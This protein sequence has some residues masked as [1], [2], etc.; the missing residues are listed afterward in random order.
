MLTGKF[1]PLMKII[2]VIAALCLVA[3]AADA[4]TGLA[5]L[6]IPVGARESALGGA[7]A[8]L[9][10]GPT[11]AVYNPALAAFIPRSAALMHNRHFGDS[12][13]E[14]VGFTLHRG[15]WALSPHYWG[16]RVSD[17]E[18]RD[19]A[20]R[21]PLS[22]FDAVH[23]AV[24]GALAYRINAHWAAG[25]TGHYIYQKIFVNSSDG[26]GL[27]GG[28]LAK[29]LIMGL[30]AG[31]AVLNVGHM[32][33]MLYE[34][35][36]LPTSVR[37]GAAYEHSLSKYGTLLVTAEG[38]GVRD[39]TPRFMGGFEYRAPGFVALRAGW[40]EGLDAQDLS[41]GFGLFYEN[42]RLDYC[43]IP[44]REDLGDGHR[45]SLAFNL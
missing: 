17:I 13:M 10:T 19:R 29:D 5:F 31:A 36:K 45:F 41:L 3:V 22:T 43:F 37:C 18:Y 20:T 28:I 24:G 26:Y 12:K 1:K 32:N 11:S 2:L 6:E 34:S 7:G 4:A 38:V 40:V 21:D 42:F 30:T 16:A 8:A 25:V 9:L 35:P 14:F 27:D 23:S 15:A 33:S 39:N 44:Y